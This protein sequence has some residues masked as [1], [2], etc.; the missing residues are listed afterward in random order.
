LPAR[1]Q[2]RLLQLSPKFQY[3]IAQLQLQPQL[4][5][6]LPSITAL[7]FKTR[8][9]IQRPTQRIINMPLYQPTPSNPRQRLSI[10]TNSTL[11]HD[12]NAAFK[13]SSLT[14]RSQSIEETPAPPPSPV[15]FSFPNTPAENRSP[16]GSESS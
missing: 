15:D 14:S 2:A 8:P 9:R 12:L 5:Q 11:G 7:S 16:S 1:Y 13:A 4:K 10:L 3:L 6:A